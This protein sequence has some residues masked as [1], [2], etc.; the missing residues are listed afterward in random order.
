MTQTPK[1]LDRDL[2]WGPWEL[3]LALYLNSDWDYDLCEPSW[4]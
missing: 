2:K 4:H 3:V 1:Y